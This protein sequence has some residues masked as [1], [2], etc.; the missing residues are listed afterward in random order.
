MI[1]LNATTFQQ[2]N[3]KAAGTT[4][5]NMNAIHTLLRQSIDYAGLFPPAG[6]GM[7]A[8]VANYLRYRAGPEAWALGR[9]I[10]PA[11]RLAEFEEAAGDSSSN[12][13]GGQPWQLSALVGPDLAGDLDQITGFQRRQGGTAQSMTVDTIETKADTV[14]TIQETM[15]RIPGR[16]Q[17]YFELPIE[18]DLTD[19]LATVAR[20]GARAKVRTGG[21]TPEA[22]PSTGSLAR[23]IHACVR[24]KV[25]FKATAGLH[26]ALRAEYRLTYEDDSGTCVMFGFLN[27]FLATA[28][29]RNGIGERDTYGILE[30]SSPAAFRVDDAAIAWRDQRLDRRALGHSRESIVSFGSCSFTEPVAELQ[31][32]HW[33]E[34]K[35]QQA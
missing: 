30:E 17:V 25:P 9:F 34:P 19:L 15:R 33:L 23:F 12:W 18:H 29:A 5:L 2:I 1:D 24:A 4:S 11:T 22:F 16:L 21:V 3:A 13:A 20:V 26:H 7:R 32:L 27:L 14:S 6:L 28:L 35:V 31:S 8:A 10:V